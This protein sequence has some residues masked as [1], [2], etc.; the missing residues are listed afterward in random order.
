MIKPT[1]TSATPYAWVRNIT[2]DVVKD[3]DF[4]LPT[5]YEI[6]D[7]TEYSITK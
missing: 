3:S 5:D 6:Y 4:D 1:Q 7:I 2:F